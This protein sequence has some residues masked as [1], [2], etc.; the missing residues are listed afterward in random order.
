MATEETSRA[1]GRAYSVRDVSR[2]EYLFRFVHQSDTP[3]AVQET[4]S[5]LYKNFTGQKL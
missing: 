3:N 4:R 1:G 2:A 5:W